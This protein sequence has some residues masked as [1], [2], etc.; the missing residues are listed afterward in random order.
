[1]SWFEGNREIKSRKIK[2]MKGGKQGEGG[3]NEEM[4]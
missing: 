3:N 2:G 1:M 4:T